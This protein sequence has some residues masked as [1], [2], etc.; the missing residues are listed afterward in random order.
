MRIE[1]N[2]RK[3]VVFR[4]LLVI[5]LQNSKIYIYIYISIFNIYIY[6]YNKIWI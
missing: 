3:I 2:V 4:V 6:I 1:I 5:F